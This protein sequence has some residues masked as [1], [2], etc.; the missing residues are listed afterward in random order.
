M[1]KLNI[2]LILSAMFL[3]LYATGPAVAL[4]TPEAAEISSQINA[5]DRIVIGTVSDIQEHYDHTIFTITVEEWLYN[6]FPAETIDVRTETGKYLW[7]EDQAEFTL[8]ESVLLM[9]RNEDPEKQLFSVSVGSP[10]KHPSSDRDA[11]IE[12]LKIQGKWQEENQTG[13]TETADEQPIGPN[14][15]SDTKSIPFT[16]ILWAAAALLGA[17]E[18]T[19]KKKQHKT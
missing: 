14:S 10:G 1:R 16:G 9:L 4:L 8:N 13:N 12:E 5:S 11:V 6:P 19:G 15:S 2:L 3:L 18:Y 17:V 7:T